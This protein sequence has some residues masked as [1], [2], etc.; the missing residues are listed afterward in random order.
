MSW[1]CRNCETENSEQMDVCEVCNNARNIIISNKL[2][3]KSYTNE[4]ED[5]K[6]YNKVVFYENSIKERQH[7][8]SKY[9]DAAYKEII[10]YAPLLLL[11]ADGGNQ[12]SQFKLG[13]L[14]LSHWIPEF[15][16][17]AFV[18]FARAANQGDAKAMEKLAYCFEN[19]IGTE[20]NLYE[21]KK[22]YERSHYKA[23]QI[24]KRL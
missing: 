6:W 22:W 3:S 9:K 2:D 23:L 11:S 19:G 24:L 1:V 17:N 5:V 10:K 4:S 14:F 12:E 20:R 16:A 8:M 18:W 13:D 7:L 21:A 15:R